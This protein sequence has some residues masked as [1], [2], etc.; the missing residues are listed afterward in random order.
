MKLATYRFDGGAGPALVVGDQV[1][2]VRQR[3]GP[4]D[5]LV[6]IIELGSVA[7]LERLQRMAEQ[8]GVDTEPLEMAKLLAP[9]PKPTKNV[10]CLGLNYQAH[11]AEG[12]GQRGPGAADQADRPEWPT[13]FT[14]A[15]TAVIGPDDTIPLHAHVTEALDWEVE[16]AIIVG[17]RGRDIAPED[18]FEYIFGYTVLNDISAREVQRRHGQQWFKGKSLDGSCPMGPWI[19][20]RDEFADPPDL[21][22]QCRVNGEVKQDS[23]TSLM[24]FD[25]PAIISGLSAGLTLEPGDII[26]TGTPEGVGFARQPPEVLKAGDIVECEIDGIGVLRNPVG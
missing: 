14:K 22:L 17:K 18:A 2:N 19:V 8:R 26:A 5:T 25:I 24:I 12:R 7:E 16:L 4:P 1:V 9:I 6:E 3:L 15:P 21:R 13:Y 20:T 23:R 10:F 11:I